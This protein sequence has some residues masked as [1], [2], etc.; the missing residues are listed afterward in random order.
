[1]TVIKPS[2]FVVVPTAMWGHLRPLLH[3]SLNLLTLHPNLHLTLLVTPS[4]LPRVEHELKS[5]SF[6]HIYTKSPSGSGT[7][8]P[9]PNVHHTTAQEQAQEDKAIADRLQVITCISP[10]FD[11]PKEWSPEVIAQEGM[12]YAKTLPK[13]LQALASKEHKLD[14]TENKFE[15]IAPNFVVY[16]SFLHFVPEVVRGVLT[17]LQKPMI[18]LI[19]FIPSNAAATWHTFAKEENGGTFTLAQ[20]LID[21]DIANG[22]D[23]LEAHGKHAFGTYGKVKTIPGLPPKFDYEWWP[24]FATVPMPPQAFM[25]IIPSAK[26]IRDPA[27]S[28]IVCP[29]TAETE[30]LAVEALEK[31]MGFRI[32]MAG[33]QFPDAAWA[34][35]HP[36]PQAQNADDANVFA[37]LD[38]MK[39]KHG[40]KS[41]IYVS[42][43]SLFFPVT[44]PELIRY[45]LQSLKES[46]FP[47]IFAYAS[48]MASLPEDLQ[49]ELNDDEDSCVVKFAPQWDVVNHEATGYFLSHCGSNSTAEA[50]LAELP[51]VSMPFAA[52]QGEFTAML[53]EVYKVSIDLKQVKTFKSPDF[54]KL[55][56][57]TV[58]VG[59]EEAIKAELKQTWDTLRGPEGE[60]MRARMRDL[61]A[62]IKKSWA[63]GR[64]KKDMLA[65]GTCFE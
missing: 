50:M 9:N 38:K 35:E 31:E 54:N 10:E 13:F 63:D 5:T 7:S 17:G 46:G 42:L 26:A 30:P 19:A 55:Y 24:N 57:G 6:A 60:A 23:V 29:T 33:P 56:D 28:G 12:D 27:V 20:R 47:F 59:T 37:F 32:Y 3:L 52:D 64:S 41:V 2:H 16:D 65:L 4:V 48:Q 21:E 11:M 43:G 40:A 14:G 22:M 44:R 53:S 51:M 1:M 39:K 58:V 15:D 45:I 8:T 25:G 34:G 61:K 36:E 62:V 18:P 49:K